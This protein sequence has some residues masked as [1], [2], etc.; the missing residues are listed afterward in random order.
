MG[1]G[2]R[3]RITTKEGY[4]IAKAWLTRKYFLLRNSHNH[5]ISLAQ[6]MVLREKGAKA[7]LLERYE[8]RVG[9]F[10]GFME[11]LGYHQKEIGELIGLKQVR[12]NELKQKYNGKHL[13]QIE[14]TITVL[15]K[16]INRKKSSVSL[17]SV[18]LAPDRDSILLMEG[19]EEGE[20]PKNQNQKNNKKMLEAVAH[21]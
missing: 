14:K 3:K 21:G 6:E 13:G 18:A 2:W 4:I 12:V 8:E 15:P 20:S 10:I 11:G 16:A 7:S 17:R 5:I 19:V 9:I 1:S